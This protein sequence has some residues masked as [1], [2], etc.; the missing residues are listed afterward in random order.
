LLPEE[1]EEHAVELCGLL[2]R[3]QMAGSIDDAGLRVQLVSERVGG[4]EI[5]HVELACHH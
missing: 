2:Q 1:F 4:A 5:R 3:R